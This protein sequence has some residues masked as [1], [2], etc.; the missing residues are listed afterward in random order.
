MDSISD[1]RRPIAS[2]ESGWARR[3]ATVLARNN[4]TPNF[5]SILSIIFSFLSLIAFYLDTLGYGYHIL[6]LILAVV[7]IQGRLIMNLLDGM[8][9]VEHNKKSVIGGLFNEVPD[10]ISDTFTLLGVGLMIRGM[11]YGMDLAYV[12]VFL[13]VTT[14]YIRTLGASLG[15]P[16]YFIG[17]MAKQHRMALVTACCAVAVWYTPIFYYALILMNIGLIIT[18]YR[19]LSKIVDCLYSSKNTA[20]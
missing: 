13:S 19:R 7:G 8:V 1:S 2:R 5:I 3:T 6:F 16:H 14:A 17:P 18:C 15:C 20:K 10:R 9:A 11:E 4:V 12:A